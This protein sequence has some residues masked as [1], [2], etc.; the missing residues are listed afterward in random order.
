MQPPITRTRK[1]SAPRLRVT[2]IAAIAMF[3][4]LATGCSNG[5][6][7]DAGGERGA[8]GLAFVLMTIF[9]WIYFASLFYMDRQRKKRSAPEE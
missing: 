8:G 2:R 5:Q 7:V 6:L 1:I 9:F 3:A 4:L